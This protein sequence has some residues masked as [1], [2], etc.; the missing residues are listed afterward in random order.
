M[1]YECFDVSINDN[2][3]HIVL[4]RPEKRNAMNQAFWADLPEIVRDIDDN[5]KAR[6]IVIS[7]TGP[8]FLPE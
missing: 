1:T 2:V 4:S 3:A 8:Y 6:A 5:S 7:S